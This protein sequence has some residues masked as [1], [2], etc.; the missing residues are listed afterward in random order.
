MYAKI[1][2]DQIKERAKRNLKIL[3]KSLELKNKKN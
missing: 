3:E 2:A 1:L